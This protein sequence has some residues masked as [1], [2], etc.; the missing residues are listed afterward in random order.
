M[1]VG[2]LAVIDIQ[3]ASQAYSQFGHPPGV[4]LGFFGFIFKSFTPAFQGGRRLVIILE[5]ER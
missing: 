3:T 5:L 1:N 4:S 2:D